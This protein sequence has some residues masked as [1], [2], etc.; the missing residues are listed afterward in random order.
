MIKTAMVAMAVLLLAACGSSSK[1]VVALDGTPRTP[2]VEG[3]VE[4]VTTKRLQLDGKRQYAVSDDVTAFSTYNRRAVSLAG[5][6]GK[7][8]HVGLR[9][10]KVVWVGQIGVVQLGDDSRTVLYQG[11]LAS[12]DGRRLKFAD[13]TVLRLAPGLTAPA[14]VRGNTFVVIDPDRHVVQG[15]TFA[16]AA[17]STTRPEK[18]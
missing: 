5:T 13:G 8:V 12:A 4:S 6:K 15:A 16:P 9:H 2:D 10:G 14:D 7:Y 17:P 18:P 11:N 1:P 3:V